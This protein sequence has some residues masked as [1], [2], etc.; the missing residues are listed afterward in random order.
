[1]NKS[2]VTIIMLVVSA[3]LIFWQCNEAKKNLQLAKQANKTQIDTSKSIA[4]HYD[5]SENQLIGLAAPVKVA[6]DTVYLPAKIDTMAFIRQFLTRSIYV[7]TFRDK[8]VVIQIKD[9]LYKNEILG[10]GIIYKILRPDSIITLTITKT[11]PA[12]ANK[13][14]V[15]A[16]AILLYPNNYVIPSIGIHS[17]NWNF[18]LGTNFQQTQINLSYNLWKR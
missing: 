4:V 18:G 6:P 15:S 11:T 14:A 10:R 17:G 3:F 1:M 7:D 16:G 12:T 8:N 13:I 9:T 5:S 2:I